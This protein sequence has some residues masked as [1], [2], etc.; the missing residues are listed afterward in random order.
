MVNKKNCSIFFL[1]KKGKKNSL[2]KGQMGKCVGE[3][4]TTLHEG[5]YRW[6]SG[7]GVNHS[8]RGNTSGWMDSENSR[9]SA[10]TD[11]STTTTEWF[12][13]QCTHC[14]TENPWVISFWLAP[15]ARPMPQVRAVLVSPIYNPDGRFM[16][17]CVQGSRRSLEY[18]PEEFL[19]LLFNALVLHIASTFS[20]HI[21][22]KL[23]TRPLK[24][25][26]ALLINQPVTSSASARLTEG[27]FRSTLV[28]DSSGIWL[29]QTR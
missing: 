19:A 13:T 9:H 29:P 14:F 16:R 6:S 23:T 25:S 18:F 17:R 4:A 22:K 8:P 24:K 3:G 27:S 7:G 1:I 28:T 5:D 11:G 10:E 2:R 26:S 20:I 12:Y 15:M 21:A